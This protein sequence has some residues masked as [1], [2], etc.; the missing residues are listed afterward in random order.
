MECNSVANSIRK[1][2]DSTKLRTET[3]QKSQQTC[4]GQPVNE[5]F[6][7]LLLLWIDVT[8]PQRYKC[9]TQIFT[10]IPAQK[11]QLAMSYEL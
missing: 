10:L 2:V 11:S 4:E 9:N 8:Q 3:E 6:N 1:E 5:V 7:W